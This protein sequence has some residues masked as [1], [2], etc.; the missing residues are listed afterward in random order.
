MRTITLIPETFR[1]KYNPHRYVKPQI[2]D[3]KLIIYEKLGINEGEAD[4]KC[5]NFELVEARQIAQAM[6]CKY[7]SKFGWNFRMIGKEI[8]GQDHA[9][10]SH[11]VKIVK[12]HYELEKGY[13]DRF[14]RIER[15]IR[16]RFNIK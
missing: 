16:C 9:S 3:F 2:R 12:C 10:V 14:D 1:V 15:I 6:C 4:I 13:A 5:R 7:K 11:A 8:G